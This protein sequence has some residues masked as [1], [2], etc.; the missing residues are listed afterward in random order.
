VAH[1]DASRQGPFWRDHRIVWDHEGEYSEVAA[2]RKDFV[3]RRKDSQTIAR[4]E[5]AARRKDFAARRKD[6]QTIARAI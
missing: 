4:G 6:S 3:A 5:V 1:P 2:R